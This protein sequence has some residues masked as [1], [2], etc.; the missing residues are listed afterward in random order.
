MAKVSA[1]A[2]DWYGPRQT[3]GVNVWGGTVGRV[4]NAPLEVFAAEMLGCGAGANVIWRQDDP[5]WGG[6]AGS[7]RSGLGRGGLLVWM[8]AVAL[9][10]RPCTRSTT[11]LRLRSMAVDRKSTR[12]NSSHH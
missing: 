12:L 7:F 9:S 1:P 5:G 11:A 6:L 10:M 2:G 8:C 3:I 4:A